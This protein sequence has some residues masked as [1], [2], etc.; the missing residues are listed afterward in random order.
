MTR[1]VRGIG[2][3][4]PFVVLAAACVP[5][6]DAARMPAD[7]AIRF[8]LVRGPAASDRASTGGASWVDYDGDGDP[9][10][11]VTNGYSLTAPPHGPQADRLYRNDGGRLVPVEDSALV[12][13]TGHSSGSAWADYDGDGDLDVFVATQRRQNDLLYVNQGHGAFRRVLEGDPVVDAASGFGAEWVDL[14]GDDWLDLVVYNGGLAGQGTLLVYRNRAGA[15]ARDTVIALARDTAAYGGAAWVDVDG[16]G[17]VDVYLPT[18][19][20]P[21]GARE[22]LWIN[23]GAGG[24]EG[25]RLP[26]RHPLPSLSPAVGDLDGDGDFDIVVAGHEGGAARILWSDGAGAFEERPQPPTLDAGGDPSL[27]ALGDFDNDGDLDLVIAKWGAASSLYANDGR[28][29][30]TRVF[31]T[32]LSAAIHWASTVALAD[33]DS[34]GLLDLYLGSWPYP[35]GPEEENLLLRNATRDAGHWLEV[36]LVG[37]APNT[38]AIGAVLAV[39]VTIEGERRTLLRRV[40]SASTWRSMDDLVQHVGIG[41]AT[42]VDAVSVR[43]PDGTREWYRIEGVDRKVEL[44]QLEGTA[45]EPR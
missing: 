31:G 33:Y 15:L 9:D 38:A 4:A 32:P 35:S 16:D 7:S 30:F 17:D 40:A 5:E 23:D 10:L 41:D 43:W 20:S 12:A 26:T 21:A 3:V 28:G 11:F 39:E 18:L 42:A 8:E 25:R 27:P 22:F 1:S 14:D 24:F 36:R 29:E 2:R 37:R 44:V 13:D 19:G 34:D 45:D 6:R